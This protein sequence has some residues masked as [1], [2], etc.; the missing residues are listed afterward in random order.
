MRVNVYVR[1]QS[2]GAGG[3]ASPHILDAVEGFKRHGID[4]VLRYPSDPAPCD[5]AV[6]WGFK[7]PACVKSGRRALILERGYI[8]DRLNEWTSVGFDGL[9]G[10]ADFRNKGMGSE[11]WEANFA[12]YLKP[13]RDHYDGK[14]VLI[15][16]QVAGDASL[17]GMNMGEWIGATARKI[18]LAGHR[19]AFRPH[20]LYRR[21]WGLP[22]VAQVLKGSLDEALA[23]AR[24][25]VCYNSNSAVDAVLAGIP[26]VTCD[27]GSM[28]WPVTGHEPHRPPSMADRTQW[29]HDMAWTQ[30]RSEEI[31]NGDAW[32][33]LKGGM[34]SEGVAAA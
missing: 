11:R 29:A 4:P 30:W 33:H 28:A 25:V 2:A 23:V 16:G 7:K 21:A 6:M 19:V 8:G 5:L 27:Q 9:N 1:N 22:H 24:W 17:R 18:S 3:G 15:M 26:T 14:Y 10:F 34:L 31:R 20:P 12:P 32:D 13:W